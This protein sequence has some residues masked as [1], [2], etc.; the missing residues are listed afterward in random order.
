MYDSTIFQRNFYSLKILLSIASTERQS[1]I[2]VWFLYSSSFR[3]QQNYS[4]VEVDFIK[5]QPAYVGQN[6]LS[7]ICKV[8]LFTND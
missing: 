6:L 7:L 8:F 5:S 4:A 1:M 2:P 3:P